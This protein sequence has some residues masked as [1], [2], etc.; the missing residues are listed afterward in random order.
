MLII[1]AFIYYSSYLILAF[2]LRALDTRPTKMNDLI[3]VTE[4]V[5]QTPTSKLSSYLIEVKYIK[6]HCNAIE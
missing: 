2:S 5:M 6:K 3:M 1:L 4:R